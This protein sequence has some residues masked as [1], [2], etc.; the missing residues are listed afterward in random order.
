MSFAIHWPKAMGGRRVSTLWD[1]LELIQPLMLLHKTEVVDN[2]KKKM[3]KQTSALVMLLVLCKCESS[4]CELSLDSTKSILN[5]LK[6][7]ASF[8]P[9]FNPLSTITLTQREHNMNIMFF[10]HPTCFPKSLIQFKRV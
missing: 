10:L 4:F 1:K 6:K 8:L 7:G 3:G 5:L 9:H 2:L